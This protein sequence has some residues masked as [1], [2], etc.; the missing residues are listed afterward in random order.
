MSVAPVAAA[1]PATPIDRTP[2]SMATAEI[3][4]TDMALLEAALG[5]QQG[6]RANTRVITDA[7]LA[8]CWPEASAALRRYLS[9]R[10]V[11]PTDVEDMV[12]ECALRVL[13]HAP[14]LLDR[15]DLLRW[16]LPVVRNLSVDAY[17]RGG[18]LIVIDDVPERPS[19]Q[20][21]HE[22]VEHRVELA[23]VLK[24]ITQLG[25][26]DREAI[27]A[28]VNGDDSGPVD[29]REAVK[30]NVRRHRARQRL[31][32]LLAGLLGVLGG[33]SRRI[34]VAAP[35]AL[36]G[37]AVAATIG[38]GTAAWPANNAT[39]RPTFGLNHAGDAQIAPPVG[40]AADASRGAAGT[41][42]PTA[43]A[44]QH[45]NPS[46]ERVSS[47]TAPTGDRVT[48]STSDSRPQ[49]NALVCESGLPLLPARCIGRPGT[50]IARAVEPDRTPGR[51]VAAMPAASRTPS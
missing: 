17:R 16:C 2:A 26:R 13:A 39:D 41:T 11:S 51:G 18:R 27:F 22:H 32:A 1:G 37:F 9:R 43:P 4:E 50:A 23:R 14:T 38:V 47:V 8:A 33:L 46:R 40:W 28:A 42:R 49:P 15:D 12:Q 34:G 20:D 29:R 44:R 7:R 31:T 25:I 6:T 36:A 5:D 19:T 21:L 45:V 3:R 48:L 35:A 30:L 10:G 24:A